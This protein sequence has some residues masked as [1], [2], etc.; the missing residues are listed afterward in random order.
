MKL[1]EQIIQESQEYYNFHKET[2]PYVRFFSFLESLKRDGNKSLIENIELGVS[3]ILESVSSA[4][5]S[6]NPT[7]AKWLDEGSKLINTDEGKAKIAQ[8][9]K[10]VS[11]DSNKVI[12]LKSV[13]P[14]MAKYVDDAMKIWDVEGSKGVEEGHDVAV[15]VMGKLTET[16][17]EK[18]LP[19][20]DPTKAKF[21]T[22]IINALKPAKEK[23]GQ[24]LAIDTVRKLLGVPQINK[25][26]PGKNY[27]YT[28]GKGDG[29]VKGKVRHDGK[30]YLRL[31]PDQTI[32]DELK[33]VPPN[34]PQVLDK[35]WI[36]G[37]EDGSTF[38]HSKI[39]SPQD[40]ESNKSKTVGVT[41]SSVADTHV[42]EQPDEKLSSK[43]FS[44]KIEGI[45]DSLELDGDLTN[46][47]KDYYK[48]YFLHGFGGNEK[49]VKLKIANDNN[50][51]ITN[52]SIAKTTSRA[53]KKF[54]EK[55][56]SLGKEFF[57]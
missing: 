9:Q 45:A 6:K 53:K 42:P 27:S 12:L 19:S 36:E 2:Q 17:F 54:E 56:K 28:K 26:A 43:T 40:V 8:A 7:Y 14:A 11:K 33:N 32:P 20:F 21:S 46:Y 10:D 29:V 51:D 49:Q 48:Q 4:L 31:G 16:I 5:Q 39:A 55:V 1:L 44:E 25:W 22:Y 18:V 35:Y 13:F 24:N 3:T 23:G 57:M 50:L 52:N 15:E 37:S 41:D 38:S 34:D 47:L 30:T